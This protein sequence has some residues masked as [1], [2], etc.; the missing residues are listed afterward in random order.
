MANFI[1]KIIL[2]YDRLKA[3]KDGPAIEYIICNTFKDYPSQVISKIINDKIYKY[4]DIFILAPSVKSHKCPARVVANYLS[5]LKIPIFVPGTDDAPLDEDVLKN[6][7]VFSTFHQVKGLERKCVFVFGFDQSYF[8]FYAKNEQKDVCPNTL[9][10]AL[11]RSKESLHI[12]HHNQYDYLSFLN[13]DMLPHFV[14]L[15]VKNKIKIARKTAPKNNVNVVDL[16][17]HLSSKIIY[18]ALSFFKY[19]DIVSPGNVIDIP[20]R[21]DNNSNNENMVET[22][23]EINGTAL[24]SY[25]EFAT[26]GEMKILDELIGETKDITGLIYDEKYPNDYT[27]DMNTK[28]L[29]KLANQ[30][31]SFRTEYIYKLTQITNYDWLTEDHLVQSI[32]IMKKHISNNCIFEIP[33]CT[34]K[35]IQNKT[36]K[37]DTT[38]Y[39]PPLMHPLHALE[40]KTYTERFPL[41]QINRQMLTVVSNEQYYYKQL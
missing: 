26:T 12:F 19:A 41:N 40:P 20:I 25:F 32:K 38:N 36:I 8:E 15:T 27:F 13:T 17:R 6:K 34:N 28:N 29:L 5:K 39:I 18:D 3:V 33:V 7:I 10:V 37:Y 21:I 30:Y 1:N 31:C 11:T 35:P 23:S 9:Y 14:N 16:I 4:D 24:A 22:V 2:N